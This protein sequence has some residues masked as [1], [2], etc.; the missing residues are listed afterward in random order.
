MQRS[1][2][3]SGLWCLR[4]GVRLPQSFF[5]CD[6][7]VYVSI[8]VKDAMVKDDL[9][10]LHLTRAILYFPEPVNHAEKG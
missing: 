6:H 8:L 7:R 2:C 4:R 3:S 9:S 1:A 10:L 5:P